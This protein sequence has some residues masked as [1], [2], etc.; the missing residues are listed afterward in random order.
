MSSII[1]V[2]VGKYTYLYESESYRNE[3]G[4][5]R[6]K[7]K[8]I[9]KVDPVTGE[10]IF[11]Q[12]YLDRMSTDGKPIETQ[13]IE[14]PLIE[15]PPNEAF[16]S[17]EDIRHSTVLNYGSFY[18][19][20]KLAE[21]MGLLTVL[22]E[23]LPSC[24]KEVFN[25]ASYLISTGDPFSY[26][27]DWLE[28]TD[29]LPVGPMTSQRISELLAGIDQLDRDRFYHLWCSHRSESEYL[30]LDITSTSSYSELIES[31][32]WGYNRDG[33][34]LPQ[35]NIC[36]LM[37]FESRYPIYQSVYGGSLKDVTTLTT[38]IQTFQAL[39]GEKPMIS[40][41]D[42]GF[43]SAK[44]VNTMLSDKQHADFIIAVP[45]TNKFA[46]GLV[47]SEK[48]DID[49]LNNTIVCGKESLRAITKLR[50]WNKE[51][52]VYAHVYYNARKAHGI[53][54]NLFA[55]VATLRE[56]AM[57]QPEKYV[58]DREY[59]KYLII[60]RS[61]REANGYTVNLREDVVEAELETAGWMVVISNFVADAKEAIKIYREKDIVEKGFCRLKNTLDMGRLRVHSEEKMQNKVFIGFI[62][63]ILL[64]GIHNVMVDQMLYRTM[65]MKKLIMTLSKLKV[66]FVNEVRILFPV[67]KAQRDIYN[68]F[69]IKLPV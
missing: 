40:V 27:E 42:K 63:L 16:F 21:Q 13:P 55:H 61:E 12:E 22:Q 3:N 17:E 57:L 29:A 44:N 59:T 52:K 62:S 60:R 34:K 31:V 33:E 53:R 66:Q 41:M 30:A 46:K 7:R 38:T 19:Y 24:W 14:R 56:Q 25:L 58:N 8:I 50:S 23:A 18:L 11:K 67:T 45:F 39:A 64:S 68:A 26:C 32:E 54:E 43:F 2:K 1:R 5:P 69:N 65:T 35:I 4:E 51:H 6:N 15:T 28:K 48:K 36:L 10:Y 20:N 49:T 37:G 47:K 9:G